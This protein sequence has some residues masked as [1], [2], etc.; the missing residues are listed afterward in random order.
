MRE[1]LVSGYAQSIQ[2]AQSKPAFVVDDEVYTYG[3]L[4]SRIAELESALADGLNHAGVWP[5]CQ[6]KALCVAVSL[7]NCIDVALCYLLS[8]KQGYLFALLDPSWSDS[9]RNHALSLLCPD[10]LVCA[11]GWEKPRISYF[12]NAPTEH[13]VVTCHQLFFAG[14]TSGSSGKPKAFVRTAHS[15]VASFR[16]AAI[17]FGTNPNS[18]IVAPGPLSHGLSFFAMAEAF[19][20]GATFVTQQ[21]FSVGPCLQMLQTGRLG[22]HNLSQDSA[23]LMMVLVPSM[24]HAILDRANEQLASER[25]IRHTDK[26]QTLQVIT[27]GAKLSGRIRERSAK[28]FPSINLSE[29]YGASELSFVSVATD[30]ERVPEGSVGRAFA[31]VLVSIVNAA[32]G[33]EATKPIDSE[34]ADHQMAPVDSSVSGD[35]TGL[36]QVCSD[37]LASG[38]LQRDEQGLSLCPLSTT[39]WATVGD[40]G[41]LDESGFLYLLDRDDRMMNSGGLKVY[42]S[43]VEQAASDYFFTLQHPSDQRGDDR[44]D[45]PDCVVVGLPDEYWG[46][47]VCLVLSGEHWAWSDVL[48]HKEALLGFCRLRLQRHE[49]PKQV[50]HC[51]RLPL[52]SSGKISY[53]ELQLDLIESQGAR[54]DCREV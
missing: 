30:A 49:M 42:P 47:K 41:Y 34:T 32:D 31:S 15:W 12:V 54:S 19:Y 5:A 40:R 6:D 53:R 17:E 14:F 36:V 35:K 48:E 28:H 10:V 18:I 39:D 50:F 45:N 44:R 11:D 21:V 43:V 33:F 1:A 24:L 27:A 22:Q 51:A 20:H 52:T 2:S 25:D 38:Y 29:Y 8:V 26:S 16:A 37:L 13:D 9:E 4:A 46:E 3:M 7:R 23:V